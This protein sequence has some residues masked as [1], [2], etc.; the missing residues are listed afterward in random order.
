[1]PWL[2]T[3]VRDQRIQFVLTVAAR[4]GDGQRGLPGVR[5]QP[6]DRLQ[7]AGVARRR[8]ARWRCSPIGVAGRTTVPDRTAGRRDRS[9]RRR[10][11]RARSAGAGPSWR[12]CWPPKGIVLTPRTIDRID[13]ARGLDAARQ[14]RRRRRCSASRMPRPN[15]LWQMDAK[16]AYPL[17]GPA[18]GVT[19]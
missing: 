13:P 3:D 9:A 17:R 15:E 16:G 18:A 14:R 19:R 10:A 11:A 12:R 2:E 1:M 6:Q 5:H 8:R 4:R 7:V